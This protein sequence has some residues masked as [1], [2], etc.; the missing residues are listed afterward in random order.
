MNGPFLDELILRALKEDLGERGDLT[1]DLVLPEEIRGKAGIWVKEEAILCGVGIAS[2]VLTL[3]D[4]S[5]YVIPLYTDGDMVSP[6]TLVMEILGDLRSIFSAERTALN[7]LG[8]L[9]GIATLVRKFVE[10][11]EGTSVELLDTRKTTPGLRKLEKYAVQVGGGKN[12]RMGLFDGILIKDNHI[13]AVG[14]VSEAV[15]KA[16]ANAPHGLKVEAEVQTL[17]E[18]EEALEAGADILLLDNMDLETVRQAVQMI[19]D[20]ALVEVSGGITLE[21]VRSYAEAGVDY[22]SVGALTH[23]ARW[24]DFSLEV[25]EVW[26]P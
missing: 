19:Q 4:P 16:K 2:R 6:Q 9:S 21:N 7:F 3:M 25:M 8:R 22:I 12:H 23:Q 11:L 18:V 5:L 20:R 17:K 24:I 14:S 15:R 13:R 10:A 1:T 26:K